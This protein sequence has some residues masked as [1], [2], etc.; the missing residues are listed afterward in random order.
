[1]HTKNQTGGGAAKPLLSYLFRKPEYDAAPNIQSL[2]LYFFLKILQRLCI[3][4]VELGSHCG[5]S[6]SSTRAST[7]HPHPSHPCMA[8]TILWKDGRRHVLTSSHIIIFI[9]P[10]EVCRASGQHNRQPSMPAFGNSTLVFSSGP[11]I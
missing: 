9:K 5:C 10:I 7:L 11:E 8:N 3:R 1:M 2:Y 4:S 6:P